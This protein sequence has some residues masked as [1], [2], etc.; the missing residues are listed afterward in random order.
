[1]LRKIAILAACMI[2]AAC[3]SQSGN[4]PKVY[5]PGSYELFIGTNQSYS[6][7]DFI[8]STLLI[9]ADGTFEQSC[10]YTNPQS[11]RRLRLKLLRTH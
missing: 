5:F 6:R 11:N 4:H 7:S 2:Q 8:R 3:G 9:R 10:S 1:M